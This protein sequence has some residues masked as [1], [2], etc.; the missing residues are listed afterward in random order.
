LVKLLRK[1][2]MKRIDSRRLIDAGNN[3]LIQQIAMC[4]NI[5]KKMCAQKI[6]AKDRKALERKIFKEK[7]LKDLNP[8]KIQD[9]F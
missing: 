6:N 9:D 7:I 1:E 3:D 4:K 8:A 5:Q 2:E